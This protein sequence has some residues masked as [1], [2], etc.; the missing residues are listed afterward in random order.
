MAQFFKIV[1][2]SWHASGKK[3]KYLKTDKEF[4]YFSLEVMFFR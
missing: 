4:E 2:T 3:R 1:L